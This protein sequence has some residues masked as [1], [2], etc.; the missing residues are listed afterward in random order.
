[1]FDNLLFVVNFLRAQGN[2]IADFQN[3]HRWQTTVAAAAR[4]TA[5]CRSRVVN[6]DEFILWGGYGQVDLGGGN[7]RF[8]R[9]TATKSHDR[10]FN[11]RNLLCQ[12]TQSRRKPV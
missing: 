9:S 7:G 8:C 4:D 6:D 1:L 12:L 11:G 3:F 2:I 10:L 5:V